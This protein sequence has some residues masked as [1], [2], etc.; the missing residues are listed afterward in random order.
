MLHFEKHARFFK[1]K[2]IEFSLPNFPDQYL[3]DYSQ[4]PSQQPSIICF[5]KSKP[6][7]QAILDYSNQNK[8]PLTTRGLGTGKS[9]GAI[10]TPQGIL[11]SLEKM[12]NLIEVD[13]TNR[14]AIVEPGLVLKDLKDAAAA[15]QLFYPPDPS[16]LDMCSIGGN[17]AE[18]AGGSRCLKY[19]VTR[20]YVLGLKGFWGDGSPFSLGGKLHK[21][22]AG[23]DLISLL[24]GSEGTLGIVTEITL[25]LIPKPFCSSMLLCA[26]DTYEAAVE[27][28]LSINKCGIQPSVAEVFDDFCLNAIKEKE[29]ISIHLPSK[30]VFL[31]LEIESDS[32]VAVA[33]VLASIKKLVKNIKASELSVYSSELEQEGLWK[34]RRGMSE[35]LTNISIKKMSEDVVV[36]L[37]M[38]ACFFEFMQ[39]L[40]SSTIQVL[41]YGHAG[42]GNIHVNILQLKENVEWE[43]EK[44]QLLDLIFKKVIE[45]GGSL[46]G[47]HG[48]GLSKK[49]YLPLMFDENNL[50]K[51]KA[52]KAIFDPNH[53]LN[54]DKIF[55]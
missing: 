28:L 4:L 30:K 7:V 11:V 50:N 19:G 16:S 45:L 27:A 54:P 31:L 3:N 23:Y 1:S 29:A 53:I 20:E 51:M 18:N 43:A 14:V 17:I 32:K 46:T 52:L 22:V 44:T 5:P 40:S 37:S 12:N 21:N 33:G 8:V 38:L 36:P 55:L 10:A 6:E 47:E 2:Q 35:A 34:I 24:V 49:K 48:V 9:G 25:K 13:S 39:H 26:F 15:Q 42:D 41:G